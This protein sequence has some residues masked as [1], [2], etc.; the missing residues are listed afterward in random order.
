MNIFHRIAAA[1][2]TTADVTYAAVELD[3][4]A[5]SAVVGRTARILERTGRK[6]SVSG[7]TNSLGKALSVEIVHACVMYDCDKSGKSYLLIIRNA[8]HVPE[9]EEC[10]IHPIMM[11]LVG[12][13][14][15]ECPK[16]LSKVPSET[17]HSI[18]FPTI[19][20]R[21]PLKLTGVISYIDCRM[22]SDDELNRND[23]VLDITPNMDKWDPRTMDLDLQEDSMVDFQGNIK[24]NRPKK[25]VIS[26]V[27]FRSMDPTMFCDDVLNY[28]DATISSVRFSND[29]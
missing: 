24:V 19:D 26:A 17:N 6:A 4:H 18:Y 11:R 12:V 5:D 27:A 9:M 20:L 8:L 13:E 29:K 21:I 22:P 3:S 2:N 15:D 16:F 23:G 28:V 1:K 10:L 25:F 7:F 14:V